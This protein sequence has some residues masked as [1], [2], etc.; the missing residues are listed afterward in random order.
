MLLQNHI[1]PELK[2]HQNE[3][4]N[5]VQNPSLQ[6]HTKTKLIDRQ[7]RHRFR[8]IQ[9]SVNRYI[10]LQIKRLNDHSIPL[11]CN[12]TLRRGCNGSSNRGSDQQYVEEVHPSP[13]T[14]AHRPRSQTS[15][16]KKLH[17]QQASKDTTT[18]P[19]T[20][21]EAIRDVQADVL[22]TL[23]ETST[24]T[25]ST[26]RAHINSLHIDSFTQLKYRVNKFK[27]RCERAIR[28]CTDGHLLAPRNGKFQYFHRFFSDLLETAQI[29]LDRVL[30]IQEYMEQQEEI[31]KFRS[32]HYNEFGYKSIHNRQSTPFTQCYQNLMTSVSSTPAQSPKLAT[33]PSSPEYSK[34]SSSSDDSDD[35]DSESDAT[36]KIAWSVS[37]DSSSD[38]DE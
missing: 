4:Q 37:S 38:E 10:D 22:S 28:A 29:E 36:S 6:N 19:G 8:L 13:P 33:S 20:Q 23:K 27:V 1:G 18:M 2:S 31:I 9:E 34:A 24:F 17:Q 3:S 15:Q 16:I 21:I 14:P 35:S 12:Q 26:T 32:D 5:F 30:E 25:Y 11:V 7:I